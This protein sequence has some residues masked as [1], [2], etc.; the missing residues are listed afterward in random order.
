MSEERELLVHF[1]EVDPSLYAA[2]QKVAEAEGFLPGEV[3]A[4]SLADA[5]MDDADDHYR[6]VDAVPAELIREYIQNQ[7]VD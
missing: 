5:F 4:R 2:G 3:S 7:G 1:F 6:E